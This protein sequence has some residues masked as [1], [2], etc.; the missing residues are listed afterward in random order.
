MNH[1]QAATGLNQSRAGEQ[2]RATSE[3]RSF[4]DI[5]SAIFLPMLPAL[6][7]A[8]I[9]QG[10]T[11]VFVALNL[12][13]EGTSLHIVLS[14]ISSSIFYFLPF[15]LAASSAKAFGTSPYLAIGVVAFFLAPEMVEV[16]DGDREISLL[17]IP[18]VKTTYTSAVI[19][20]ILMVWGMSFVHR[21]TRRVTPDLL[22]TVLVPPVTIAVTTIVGLLA[23][24]P[25]GA[26]LTQAITWL[27]TFLNAN[28]AWLVPV[29]VGSLGALLISVGLSFALF[30]I[31]LASITAQGVDSVYG[32]GM[33][34][35]NMALA[36]M[37]LA[38]ALKARNSEYRSF[39]LSASLTALL[40]VAQP[41]LY[42]NAIALRRPFFAV[43]AGG[44]SGGLVAGLA[45]FQVFTLSP[46]ALPGIPAYVEPAGGWGNLLIAAVVMITAFAISFTAAWF[47][48]Y[49][50]PDQ[51]TVD[52]ITGAK[53]A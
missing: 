21:G 3:R 8:G 52:E 24:G 32:P 30:P 4:G 47:L 12:L 7:G 50:Q 26:A 49:E 43:I 40:G 6:I 36:G 37:A 35:S 38:V 42:G 13:D 16:M 20:I 48:G 25:I 27:I 51:T 19:P 29:L 45:G 31:A 1:Q 44:A 22:A 23:L 33:L 53:E 14:T 46:A 28:A 11:S 39:S 15:L 18:V 17:G 5:M 9:L 34:A 10:I 2:E 41:A